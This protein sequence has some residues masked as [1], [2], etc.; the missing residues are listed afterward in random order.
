MRKLCNVVMIHKGFFIGLA[1]LSMLFFSATESYSFT[2]DAS[3]G[4][5]GSISPSGPVTVSAGAAQT[6]TITPDP[7]NKVSDILVDGASEGPT[8]SY[9]FT[10]VSADQSIEASVLS[11]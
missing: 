7:D 11:M 10:N 2:I 8:L 4:P 6:F 5:G 1:F 3:A 9:T